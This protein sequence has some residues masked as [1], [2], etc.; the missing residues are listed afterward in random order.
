MTQVRPARAEPAP[1]MPAG[2]GRQKLS[3]AA[4]GLERNLSDGCAATG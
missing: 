4:S 2:I 1:T 3:Q